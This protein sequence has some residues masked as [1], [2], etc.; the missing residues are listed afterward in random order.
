MNTIENQQQQ[1]QMPPEYA[2]N[3]NLHYLL[4]VDV[5]EYAILHVESSDNYFR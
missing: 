1:D 4:A 2:L 5:Y 3:M